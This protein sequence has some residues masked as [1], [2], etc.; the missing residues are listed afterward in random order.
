MNSQQKNIL[1]KKSKLDYEINLL[2][3]FH[4]DTPD[5]EVQFYK[6]KN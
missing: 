3:T 2:S 5:C 6:R 1:L 4:K